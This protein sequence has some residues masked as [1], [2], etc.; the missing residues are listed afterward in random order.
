MRFAPSTMP[1]AGSHRPTCLSKIPGYLP[2]QAR[3]SPCASSHSNLGT[4]RSPFLYGER[5]E[6]TKRRPIDRPNKEDGYKSDVS[7]LCYWLVKMEDWQRAGAGKRSSHLLGEI[8]MQPCLSFSTLHKAGDELPTEGVRGAEL[9]APRR[10]P[11]RQVAKQQGESLVSLTKHFPR[12]HK[13]F[14]EKP[15]SI[16]PDA[17]NKGFCETSDDAVVDI[18][19]HSSRPIDG[20]HAEQ[21]A[22]ETRASRQR[23]ENPDSHSA[24]C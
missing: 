11:D 23:K 1:E 19:L 6:P 10:C 22:Q 4:E 8:F 2:T 9:G 17:A 21:P 15:P 24:S 14:Q 5:A 13:H 3:L 16:S 18:N 20:C 7:N 12:P